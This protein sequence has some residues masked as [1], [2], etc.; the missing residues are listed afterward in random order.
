MSGMKSV[1]CGIMVLFLCLSLTGCGIQKMHE[2]TETS[3]ERDTAETLHTEPEAV[4]MPAP[5]QTEPAPTQELA[6]EPAREPLDSDFVAVREYIPDMVVELKYA[7]EDNFTGQVIYDFQEA[8]LR[9]GTVK[10]LMA[11]QEELRGQKL[12]LKIWDAFRPVKAQFVLWEVLPDSTYVANPQKGF[13]SHSRGNTVDVTLV[14]ECG[15]EIE[16]PT[17]FDDF[18]ALADRDYSECSF[19]VTLNVL[20]LEQTMERHGFKGYW[21]E[22]WHFADTDVYPVETDFAP[23]E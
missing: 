6:W 20:L 19:E 10:K 18:T 17:E 21:G 23:T 7:A 3:P 13:S 2:I 12:S 9:Y 22:W 1:M 15:Q 11:V 4:E 5:A 8:Y 14:D 16:M